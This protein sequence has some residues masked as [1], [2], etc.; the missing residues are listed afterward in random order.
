MRIV[1]TKIFGA[2]LPALTAGRRKLVES[3][4]ERRSNEEDLTCFLE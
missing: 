1:C 4:E 3:E 2:F